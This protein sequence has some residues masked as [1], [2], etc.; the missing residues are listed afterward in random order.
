MP[1]TEFTPSMWRSGLV[2][3]MSRPQIHELEPDESQHIKL[4]SPDTC[5]RI[6]PMQLDR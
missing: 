1:L 2:G 3:E 5:R 6:G 4:V